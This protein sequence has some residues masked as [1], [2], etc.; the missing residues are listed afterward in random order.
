MIGCQGLWTIQSKTESC[1]HINQVPER[2]LE[3]YGRNKETKTNIDQGPTFTQESVL[4]RGEGP[5]PTIPGFLMLCCQTVSTYSAR[6]VSTKSPV[7]RLSAYLGM[8][9]EAVVYS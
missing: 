5:S 7:A 3:Q 1:G 2:R 4:I 6:V 9:Q 8:C